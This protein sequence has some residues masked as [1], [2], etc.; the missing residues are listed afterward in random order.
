VRLDLLARFLLALLKVRSVSLTELELAT[1]FRRRGVV[2]LAAKERHPVPPA[3]GARHPRAQRLD[4][5]D[6]ARH[7]VRL[8]QARREPPARPGFRLDLPDRPVAPPAN[9]HPFQKTLQRPLKS[10]FRHGLDFP[11]NVA[12]NLTEK[13]QQFLWAL[14]VLSCT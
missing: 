6:A 1:S 4:P 13:F 2:P 12:L 3:P 10:L 14:E 5:H 11:R 8:A 7:A 9:P